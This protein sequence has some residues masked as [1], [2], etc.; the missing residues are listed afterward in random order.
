M[1]AAN[2]SMSTTLETVERVT[3]AIRHDLA[4]KI[5]DED[6]NIALRGS[7]KVN[8]IL[9]TFLET[10]PSLF[11]KRESHE[12]EALNSKSNSRALFLAHLYRS[13]S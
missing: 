13:Q 11:L 12:F 10:M 4:D 5:M 2:P 3:S 1:Q 8:T 7:T 9:V 6:E